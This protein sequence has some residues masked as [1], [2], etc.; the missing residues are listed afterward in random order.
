MSNDEQFR[1]VSL[2]ALELAPRLLLVA[3]READPPAEDACPL[4]EG[5]QVYHKFGARKLVLRGGG[6]PTLSGDILIIPAN[7][8]K[9]AGGS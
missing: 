5:E 1:F 8:A 2:L 4:E 7:R 9:P 3:E 6:T